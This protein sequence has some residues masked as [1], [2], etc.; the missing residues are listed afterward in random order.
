MLMRNSNQAQ[1]VLLYT[2][3]ISSKRTVMLFFMLMILFLLLFLW[4]ISTTCLDIL[5]AALLGLFLIFLFYTVNFRTLVIAITQESLNLKFGIFTWTEHLE[6][7]EKSSLDEIPQYKRMGG[8]GVHYMFIRKRYR[9]SFNFLEYPRLVI[10]LKKKRGPVKDVS[11]STK[12]PQEIL[13][14]LADMNSTKQ[15]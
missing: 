11:F 8:A 4:R 7:I 9:V 14:H 13:H 3:K 15:A 10:A 2:E 12:R 6:N 1:T 5:S